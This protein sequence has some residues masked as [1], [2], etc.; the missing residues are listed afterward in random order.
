MGS[1]PLS[2]LI[3]LIGLTVEAIV[4]ALKLVCMT[5]ILKRA[6]FLRKLIMVFERWGAYQKMSKRKIT[7]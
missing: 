2:G 7:I 5:Q 6:Y 1:V 4:T 3:G